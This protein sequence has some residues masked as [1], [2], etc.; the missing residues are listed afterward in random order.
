M[1]DGPIQR[2]TFVLAEYERR[3][4]TIELVGSLQLLGV[5]TV[6]A[7]RL[8]HGWLGYVSADRAANAESLNLLFQM[9]L[10]AGT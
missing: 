8:W 6:A 5:W 7:R 1:I 4:V 10:R 9:S 2:P 3:E